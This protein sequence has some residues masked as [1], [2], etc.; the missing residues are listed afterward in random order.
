MTLIRGRKKKEDDKQ[1]VKLEEIR[2][3]GWLNFV[4]L[5]A[6]AAVAYTDSVVVANVSL[7]YLYVLP[8]ALSALVN[9][10][11]LTIG[12]AVVCTV[13]QDLFFGTQPETLRIRIF[14]NV[15]TLIGFLV[16]AFLVN[17]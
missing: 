1:R 8:I 2:I 10:P 5:L 7:G 11:P 4:V 12:L 3:T 16:V 9:R 14:R 6:M 15:I 17:R 13:F